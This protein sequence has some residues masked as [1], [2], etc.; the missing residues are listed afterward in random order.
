M[1]RLRF[2][3]PLLLGVALLFAAPLSPSHA[4]PAAIR[5]GIRDIRGPLPASAAPPFTLTVLGLLVAGAL[6]LTWWQLRRRPSV[7]VPLPPETVGKPVE[8][9]AGLAAWYRRGASPPDLLCLRLAALVRSGLACR[10]GL[11]ASRLTTGELL[12]RLSIPDLLTER[13]LVLA[14]QLLA[15]CDRVKFAGHTPDPVEAEWLLAAAGE[16]LDG[17]QKDAA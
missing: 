10:T 1:G 14:G 6:T 3:I 4:S 2:A 8:T 5:T 17:K 7:P 11:P 13:E 9:V 15:F 12:D 16:L